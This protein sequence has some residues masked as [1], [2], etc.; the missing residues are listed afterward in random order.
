MATF[1]AGLQAIDPAA[2]PRLRPDLVRPV[3]DVVRDRIEQYYAIWQRDRLG[4]SAI[5]DA[6]FAWLRAN[7][8]LIDDQPVIVHG[9]FDMRNVLSVSGHLSAVLDWEL[10]RLG[11]RMEDLAYIL[12]EVEQAMPWEDFVAAYRRAGGGIVDEAQIRYFVIWSAVWRIVVVVTA[13]SG[14]GRAH[15][16]FVFGSTAY[17]EYDELMDRLV[18][19]LRELK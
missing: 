9:D 19:C 16:E 1:L 7:L 14:Y 13:Y 10:S 4:P 18:R 5:V 2:V 15:C 17:I 11:H 3:R 8:S 12:Y 6:A